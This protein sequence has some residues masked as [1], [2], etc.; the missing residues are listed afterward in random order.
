M[1]KRY[2]GH[3]VI[4]CKKTFDFVLCYLVTLYYDLDL[5]LIEVASNS[6]DVE[7]SQNNFATKCITRAISTS[8]KL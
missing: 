7:L 6:P 3:L 2:I 5:L 1:D 8:R 4:Y